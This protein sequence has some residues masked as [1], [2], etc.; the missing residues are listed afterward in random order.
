MI[1]I[2]GS[3]GSPGAGIPLTTVTMSRGQRWSCKKD[4][5]DCGPHR[6]HDGFARLDPRFRLKE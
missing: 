3:N 1:V 5:C 6:D 2:P 4:H